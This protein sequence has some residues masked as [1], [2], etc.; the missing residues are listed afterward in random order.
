MENSLWKQ[1]I[2]LRR[3]IDYKFFAS[4]KGFFAYGYNTVWNT[5]LSKSRT[6]I[7]GMVKNIHYAIAEGNLFNFMAILECSGSYIAYTA[8]NINSF[9]TTASI[10]STFIDEIHPSGYSH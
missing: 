7:K 10:K 9:K 3:N 5:K 6:A 2:F 1:H 4:F 8:W